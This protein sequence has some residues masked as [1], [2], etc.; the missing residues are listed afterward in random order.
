MPCSDLRDNHL[1]HIYYLITSNLC[2]VVY[3]SYLLANSTREGHIEMFLRASYRPVHDEKD[4]PLASL[5]IYHT[6][7]TEVR[8]TLWAPVFC[9][10]RQSKSFPPP[11]GTSNYYTKVAHCRQDL[12]IISDGAALRISSAA[13]R[14]LFLNTE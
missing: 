10:Y 6:V 9:G 3:V 12:P 13:I 7:R 8:S 2:F 1:P 4:S 14:P 5:L 11:A